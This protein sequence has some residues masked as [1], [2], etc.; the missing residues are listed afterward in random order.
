[1]KSGIYQSDT[2]SI[3]IPDGFALESKPKPTE[4]V[5]E[6]GLFRTNFIEEDHSLKYIQ[7][8]EIKAGRYLAAQFEEMKTF[9]GQI[10]NL[11]NGKIGFK[12]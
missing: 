4:I 8:L 5:S 11:Q 7:T 3:R 12:K 10:E 2:I 9:F 6:F 1:L